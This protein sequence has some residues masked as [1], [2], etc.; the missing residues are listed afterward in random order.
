[1]KTQK[2]KPALN[3]PC[4]SNPEGMTHSFETDVNGKMI[5]VLRTYSTKRAKMAQAAPEL[6]EALEAIRARINGEYD[7]PSLVSIG[8]LRYNTDDDVLRIATQAIS[9]ATGEAI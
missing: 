7:N 9:R 6:L 1:M 3:A 5:N 2:H 4:Y 8:S